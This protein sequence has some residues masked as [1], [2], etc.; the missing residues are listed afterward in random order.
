MFSKNV[1]MRQAPPFLTHSRHES[2][3][4]ENLTRGI[5]ARRSPARCPVFIPNCHRSQNRGSPCGATESHSRHHLRRNT[6]RQNHPTPASRRSDRRDH[7]RAHPIRKTHPITHPKRSRRNRDATRPRLVGSP[8]HPPPHH[9]L[10]FPQSL[11][12]RQHHP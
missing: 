12:L 6:H 10:R 2:L 9:R 7:H 3:V 5:P 11:H 8:W 4:P 1:S